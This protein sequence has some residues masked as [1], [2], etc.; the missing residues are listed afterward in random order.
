MGFH[1]SLFI[2]SVRP[3]NRLFYMGSK[4]RFLLKLDEN[5]P[6]LSMPFLGNTLENCFYTVCGRSRSFDPVKTSQKSG[7]IT[8]LSRFQGF[9]TILPGLP[10]GSI[11]RVGFPSV[12]EP[13]AREERRTTPFVGLRW[14]TQRPQSDR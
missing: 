11:H 10:A 13:R 1:A 8:H 3:Y 14:R 7:Q 6:V 5:A 12:S 9:H 4:H 2:R